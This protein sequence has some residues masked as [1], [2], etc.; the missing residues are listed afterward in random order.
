M[1]STQSARRACSSWTSAATTFAVNPDGSDQQT[2][3]TGR[4]LPDSIAVDTQAGHICWT[5]MGNPSRNDGS[6]AASIDGGNRTT[7]IPGRHVPPAVAVG[8]KNRRLYW[9]DREGCA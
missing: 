4:R 6:I 3:V 8:R 7:I 5:S 9:C 1:E 2:L